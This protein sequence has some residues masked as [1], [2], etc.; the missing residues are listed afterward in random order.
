MTIEQAL[1]AAGKD[2][3]AILANLPRSLDTL[4]ACQRGPGAPDARYQGP[5]VGGDETDTQ[6]PM[7]GRG[8]EADNPN[9]A[10]IDMQ[11]L[12]LL[13]PALETAARQVR[14][15]LDRY[16]GIVVAKP[17]KRRQ[18]IDPDSCKSCAR[19]TRSEFPWHEPIDDRRPEL[20]LCRWCADINVAY[21][22]LPTVTLVVER[23]K[24]GADGRVPSTMYDAEMGAPLPKLG[25]YT[26]RMAAEAETLGGGTA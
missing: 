13:V 3:A 5:D 12:R 8:H 15:I 11:R 17:S 19:D 25:A 2:T 10:N 4:H 18:T 26:Q 14:D 24:R 21:G 7:R 22:K 20:Q 23:H 1:R 9:A 6:E 16:P